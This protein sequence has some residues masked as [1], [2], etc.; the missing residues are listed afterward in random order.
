MAAV[1]YDCPQCGASVTIVPRQ[2][3]IYF[4]FHPTLDSCSMWSSRHGFSPALF[5]QCIA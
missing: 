3:G 5:A 2:S 1:F 4:G